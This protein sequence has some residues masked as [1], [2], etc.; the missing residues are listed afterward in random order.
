[1]YPLESSEPA[2]NGQ[3]NPSAIA[4]TR[5]LAYAE[6]ANDQI[7]GCF[8]IAIH[9]WMPASG[10]NQMLED[11]ETARIETFSDSVFAIAITFLVFTVSVPTHETVARLGLLH[12]LTEIWPAY[13]AFFTSFLTIL[14]MWIQHHLMFTHIQ[15]SDHVLLLLNGLLLLTVAFVPFPT[16]VLAEYLLR[17]DAK[18]AASLY[19]GTFLTASIVNYGLWCFVSRTGKRTRTDANNPKRKESMVITKQYRLAPFLYLVAFGLSFIS[20][21]AG[22]CSTLLIALF[23]S[24]RSKP[25]IKT[26]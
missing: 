10:R 15:K 9:I 23:L 24:L 2:R 22:V 3:S 21:F 16:S 18:V 6:S 12:S 7:N 5:H 14:V 19:T 4:V 20:E 13:L 26:T 17:P 1:V 11:N 25:K 8:R